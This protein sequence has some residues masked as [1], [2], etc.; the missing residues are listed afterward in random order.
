[1]R[2]LGLVY[3]QIKL[4]HSDAELMVQLIIIEMCA[5][6]LKNKLRAQFRR[7]LKGLKDPSEAPFNDMVMEEYNTIFGQNAGTFDLWN[8]YVPSK[9]RENFSV[10]EA[11]LPASLHEY[12]RKIIFRGRE[13]GKAYLMMRVNAMTGIVIEPAVMEQLQAEP[14]VRE[15]RKNEAGDVQPARADV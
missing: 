11:D 2:Y 15:E 8:D 7:V 12:M 4:F 6:V 9:L 13:S 10:D 3:H 14:K 1:M 5:R